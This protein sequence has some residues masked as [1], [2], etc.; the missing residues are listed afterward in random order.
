MQ[1]RLF[2]I[3]V[4]VRSSFWIFLLL[5]T[6]YA[7]SDPVKMI[8]MAIIIGGSLLIHELGHAF[9]ARKF[10]RDPEITIEAFGGY[11]TYSS[12]GL[13][14]KKQ[15]AITFA[16]P[17]FTALLIV[18]PYYFLKNHFFVLYWPNYFSYHLMQM[19]IYWLLVNLA[20]LQPLDGGKMAGFL[21]RKCFG[22][23]GDYFSIHLGNVTALAGTAYFL[24][25]GNYAFAMLFAFYG[26]KNFQS[27]QL[28]RLSRS[29]SNPFA[30]LNK[31][32]Q[33]SAKEEFEEAHRIFKPLS[34]SK[35]DYIRNHAI[36]SLAILLE[37]QGNAKDAYA[38]LLKGD[39]EKMRKGSELF[40]KLAYCE[41]HY[42]TI[43]ERANTCYQACPTLD[44]ALLNAK[45]FAQTKHLQLARGWLHTARQFEE[46]QEIDWGNVLSDPGLAEL[47][48]FCESNQS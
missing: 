1:F 22:E 28:Q 17:L 35:D 14:E 12:L 11:A 31:A 42:E 18:L 40:L 2:N 25:Q 32:I 21:L 13:D 38:L 46:A 45:A 24:F 37:R 3:P 5:Y 4:F 33:L 8:L 10:G 29:P 20:P 26:M 47:R 23:R 27:G 48:E 6:F 34:R 16:G 41:G 15:F 30:L 39:I 36:E 9:A 44:V 19:N 43:I 7:S